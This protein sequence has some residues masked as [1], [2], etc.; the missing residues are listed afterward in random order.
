M[1]HKHSTF[2]VS[3]QKHKRI[4]IENVHISKSNYKTPRATLDLGTIA[5]ELPPVSTVI[6]FTLKVQNSTAAMSCHYRSN[7]GYEG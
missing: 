3:L 4:K 7:A 2:K 5:I 6:V 1:C